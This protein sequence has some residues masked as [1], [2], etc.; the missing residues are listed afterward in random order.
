MA[1]GLWR[2]NLSSQACHVPVTAVETGV[3]KWSAGALQINA[4]VQDT[5]LGRD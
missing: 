1:T 5:C 4:K 2:S 3:P